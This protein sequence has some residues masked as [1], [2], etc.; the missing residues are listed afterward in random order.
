[1]GECED[2]ELERIIDNMK[3]D[4]N[5]VITDKRA[6]KV[7]ALL[8]LRDVSSAVVK[9]DDVVPTQYVELWKSRGYKIIN[10]KGCLEIKFV[11]R[12]RVFTYPLHLAKVITKDSLGKSIVR[13]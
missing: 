7:I 13:R 11:G 10:K 4:N 1:M 3:G 2:Y 8:L 6:N 12:D 5:V 9:E